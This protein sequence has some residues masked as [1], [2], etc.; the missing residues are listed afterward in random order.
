MFEKISQDLKINECPIIL[1]DVSGSTMDNFKNKQTIRE[2]EFEIAYNICK[3]SNYKNAH[4]ITWSNKAKIY[5]NIQVEEIMTIKSITKSKGGTKLIFGMNLIKPEFFTDD[6]ICDL[7]IIT[8]GEISD[9]KEVISEK[10]IELNQFKINIK[11]IAVESNKN[12]YLNSNSS[13]GNTLYKIIRNNNMTRLVNR[14][15]VFNKLEKEFVNM[16]NP[17]VKQGY[18]PFG[19]LMF[20]L[21]DFNNFIYFINKQIS[22]LLKSSSSESENS[23][24][25]NG[26]IL[27]LVQDLALTIYHL[28]KNKSF[29]HQSSIIELFSNMFKNT[30]N[31][32]QVRSILL[33][34]I[35]NHISGKISTFAELRKSK[36]TQIEDSNLFL[37]ANTQ[38]AIS[39]DQNI[40]NQTKYSFLLK[41]EKNDKYYIIKSF[42]DELGNIKIGSNC[43]KNSCIQIGNNCV[44]IIFDFNGTNNAALQWMKFNYSRRLNISISNEYIYYYLMCDTYL[45]GDH[46]VSKIYEKYIQLSLTETKFGTEITILQDIQKNKNI[47]IPF[48]IL[49]DATKYFNSKINPLALYYVICNKYLLP[50]LNQNIKIIENLRKYC[51]KDIVE[52]FGDENIDWESIDEKFKKLIKDSVNIILFNKNDKIIIEPHKYNNIDLECSGFMNN[53]ADGHGICNLCGNT[54]LYS[55]ISKTNNDFQI[56]KINNSYLFNLEK[57]I[58]LGKLDGIS[59]D[60]LLIV[61]KF[62]SE[63][64]S[65]SLENTIIIDPISNSRLKISNQEEF[66]VNVYTKY[67]FLKEIN[68]DNIALCG[69]F[70]RS[71]LLKQQ[72][73]DFDFFFYGLENNNAY[74][75]KLKSLS[76]NIINSLRKN[77]NDIKFVIFY[78]PMFNV[79]EMICYEDPGNFIKEDFTLDYFDKYDFKNMRKLHNGNNENIDLK[80]YFEDNDANGIKMKYRF[81]LIMCKYSSILDILKSFD[82]FPSKVA[83]DGTKVYFTEKS[84]TAFQF[85]INEI[86]LNGGSDL[87]KHRVNKYFKYGFAIVFPEINRNWKDEHYGNFYQQEGIH[88]KGTNE[89]IG[90]LSFKVRTM[91]DNMIYIN[92]NSNLEQMLERNEQL[93]KQAKTQGNALYMSSL[94]CSFVAILRFVKINNINYSFPQKDNI[95]DLFE[96]DD[97]KLKNGI[98]KLTFLDAH[99]TIY[100]SDEWYETFA[101]SIILRTYK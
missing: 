51:E 34:E 10:L 45:T 98:V 38:K 2:Y 73:K 77:F 30:T 42:D 49:Q 8:D 4:I 12:D 37:M 67:P 64:E 74:I 50:Y 28:T 31:Y 24:N 82:M 18:I 59:N 81:Q 86:N 47:M 13:V 26:E 29:A 78:K 48:Y 71:I 19:D 33:N 1:I 65:F 87:V 91:L 44:P 79:L 11:I 84:L 56:P 22:N 3:N 43:Y 88:Y 23:K 72:M 68:M 97:I 40:T 89:N 35:N 92:H 55:I 83:F 62:T 27:K 46:E 54:I 85:M 25:L 39:G 58:H 90:P 94:F 60:K 93:E 5:E 99:N 52:T 63:Y 32:T 6:S 21:E 41:D 95:Y 80:Y 75:E 96:G 57:H 20:Q 16:S 100:D 70:V 101:K 36:Y 7:I 14:F 61:D 76:N 53:F 9:N 69:G 66:L 17:T 15:S